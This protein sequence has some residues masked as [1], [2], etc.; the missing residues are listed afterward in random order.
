[1]A[2]ICKM[3]GHNISDFKESGLLG[4]SECYKYLKIDE[5]IRVNQGTDLHNGKFPEKW[6]RY[7]SV[8]QKIEELVT[9]GK[10]EEIDKLDSE[11][12]MAEEEIYE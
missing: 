8:K 6:R 5:I 11:L 2:E 10:Y 3:C 4:C 9:Q 7:V 1:M 12:K